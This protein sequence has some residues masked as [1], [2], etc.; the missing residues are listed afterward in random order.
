M[1]NGFVRGDSRAHQMFN[2]FAKGSSFVEP[3][4]TQAEQRRGVRYIVATY[5]NL[6]A[7]LMKPHIYARYK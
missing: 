3:T 2:I 7:I 4:F 1:K 5:S 6:K